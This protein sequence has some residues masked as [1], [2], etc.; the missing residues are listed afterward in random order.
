MNPLHETFRFLYLSRLKKGD[1]SAAFGALLVTTILAYLNLL[2][3]VMLTDRLTGYFKWL[4]KHGVP[5]LIVLAA[6]ML[7][8]A[9]VQYL[10]W[11]HDGKLA[12]EHARIEGGALPKPAKVYCYVVI[13]ILAPPVCGILKYRLMI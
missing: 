9:T 4:G 8:V 1:S 7:A 12:R 5:T 6:G 13:S 2:V 10:C 11:I 3:L